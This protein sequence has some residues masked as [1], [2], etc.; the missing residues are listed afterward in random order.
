[1]I[2]GGGGGIM[3]SVCKGAKKRD[4]TTIGILPGSNKS[5]A[6]SFVDIAI[7]TDLGPKRNFLVASSG[8]C[9]IA[10]G[11]RWGTLNEISFGFIIG[12]PIILIDKC[13]GVVEM[14]IKSS[15]LENDIFICRKFHIY[16]Q[17]EHRQGFI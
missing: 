14:L 17:R 13:G 2:C 11:G 6:N 8:D 12:K 16:F 3:E 5:Q 7:P 10:I 1:M 15:F 9:I 4:G